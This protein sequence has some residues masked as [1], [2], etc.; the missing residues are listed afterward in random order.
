MPKR[1]SEKERKDLI[2]YC[3]KIDSRREERRENEN[4]FYKYPKTNHVRMKTNSIL[5]FCSIDDDDVKIILP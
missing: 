2:E 4:D 3:A 1:E 5:M